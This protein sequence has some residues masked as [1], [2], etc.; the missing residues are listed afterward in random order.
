MQPTF[1]SFPFAGDFESDFSLED[2]D[3]CFK[4]KIAVLS[5][6]DSPLTGFSGA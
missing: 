1:S 6:N 2:N 3:A 4:T 5:P